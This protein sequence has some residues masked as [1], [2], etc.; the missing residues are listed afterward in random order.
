MAEETGSV[1]G[2]VAE[3]AAPGTS[4][5]K[6]RKPRVAKPAAEGEPAPAPVKAKKK[7]K[8]ELEAEYLAGLTLADLPACERCPDLVR[9]RLDLSVGPLL[10]IGSPTASVL[11][12]ADNPQAEEAYR[13][14]IDWER[15]DWKVV[16]RALAAS[17]IFKGD[18]AVTY[19]TRCAIG[20][21]ELKGK[22]VSSETVSQCQ[23][24][25]AHELARFPEVRAVI[26]MGKAAAAS[27]LDMPMIGYAKAKGKMHQITVGE[28]R[29]WVVVTAH[30]FSV[31]TTPFEQ[32]SFEFDF[33]QV[34]A[35][36][37]PGYEPFSMEKHQESHAASYH[38]VTDLPTLKKTVDRLL[39]AKRVAFDTETRGLDPWHLPAPDPNGYHPKFITSIQFC[40]SENEAYF[41]PLCHQEFDI[42]QWDG[43]DR[44]AWQAELTRFFRDYTGELIAFNAKFDQVGIL[45]AL[46][47][48]PRVSMDPMIVDQLHRGM[49]A[50]SLKKLAWIVSP[51]G[52][53]EEQMNLVDVGEHKHDSYWY[54]IETLFWYGCLDVDVTLRAAEYFAKIIATDENLY[55]LSPFLAEASGV[56]SEIEYEG[57]PIDQAYL[58]EYGAKQLAIV[59]GAKEAMRKALPEVMKLYEARY[60]K[61]FDPSSNKA[62]STVL[63]DFLGLSNEEKTAKGAP[64]TGKKALKSMET[65]HPIVPRVLELRKAEKAYA[66]FYKSWTKGVAAD[67]KL[68]FRYNLIKFKDSD[69]GE[70]G[71]TNTGRLS[72]SGAAGNVQ[73]IPKDP[74][75]RKTFLPAA[76]DHLLMDVDFSTLEYVIAAVYSLDEKLCAAF[77]KGYDIHAAVAAEMFNRTPEEMSLPENKKLRARGKTMNFSALYG[78]GPEN[79]A[80]QL[81]C[82]VQEAE[83]FLERYYAKFPG[84]FE[85]IGKTKKA[86]RKTGVAY[87][88]FGR[89][90]ALPDATLPKGYGN[91]GRIE[92]ALRQAVNGPIQG[93]ASD[94]CLWGLVRVARYLKE[95][96]KRA[97]V[98]A[99]I[100]DALVLS[101]PLDELDEVS[102][103]VKEILVN[104]GL[105]WLD[106]PEGAGVPLQ[107]SAEYGL[108]WG[109]MVKEEA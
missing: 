48:L 102:A 71:G 16:E 7:T 65:A 37:L 10:A 103:K 26:C 13:F 73:Q 72:S 75:I 2:A 81:E 109:E 95:T 27:G 79:I 94:I 19:A 35:A 14:S 5:P 15:D 90:R 85:W 30:P 4:L 1:P 51:F 97:K 64:S 47:I 80:S 63:Y 20:R 57:W 105:S 100:H 98:L 36:A 67:G 3:E 9:E 55:R 23:P 107:V 92:A 53:Y 32:E 61:S 93:D 25:L 60:G 29:L 66:A 91:R 39:T 96:G 43:A 70:Q 8:A 99:T 11:I 41:V 68:H 83:D 46:K 101:V 49:P 18:V 87:S 50:R 76:E 88:K 28:R 17:G 44:Q 84:L 86:A 33:R 104:P 45:H 38:L 6:K 89:F 62:L 78:S 54:P 69:S 58:E 40:P 82:S 34:A 24:W 56:L 22:L 12:I 52:G 59:A 21:R 77:R 108:N 74:V 31:L 106:G 42:W